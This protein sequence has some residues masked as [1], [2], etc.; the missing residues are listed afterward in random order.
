VGVV[1]GREIAVRVVA[2]ERD[3]ATTTVDDICSRDVV[4]VSPDDDAAT[5]GA[6]MREHALRR[7][8][9]LEAGAVV[10]VVTLGDLARADDP[11]SGLADVS[12]APPNR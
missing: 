8:P 10:G 7:L 2:E 1:T 11:A 9:V 12:E 6:L 5:A 4:S 3:P